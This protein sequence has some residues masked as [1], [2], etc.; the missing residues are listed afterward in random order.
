MEDEA[1]LAGDRW[2]GSLGKCAGSLLGEQEW[3]AEDEFERRTKPNQSH[4]T[5]YPDSHAGAPGRTGGGER[6]AKD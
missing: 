6:R 5:I 4:R 3:Q 1:G 2:P